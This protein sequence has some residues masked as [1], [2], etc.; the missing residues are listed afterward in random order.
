L[1]IDRAEEISEYA[2][3]SAACWNSEEAVIGFEGSFDGFKDAEECLFL[4]I[5]R[6]FKTAGGSSYGADKTVSCEPLKHFRKVV[7]G[8][9]VKSGGDF[10]HGEDPFRLRGKKRHCMKRERGGV[11]N[12]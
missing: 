10:A 3:A 4:L 5:G 8:G 12:G 11:R 7:F 1:V 9:A 2:L 6:D